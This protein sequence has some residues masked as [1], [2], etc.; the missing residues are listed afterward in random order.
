VWREDNG[1]KITSLPMHLFCFIRPKNPDTKLLDPSPSPRNFRFEGRGQKGFLFFPGLTS[2]SLFCDSECLAHRNRHFP[3]RAPRGSFSTQFLLL[4]ES[5]L[6][7]LS[8][9][10][11]R[12]L[13]SKLL[14]SPHSLF[15]QLGQPCHQ[16]HQGS[17]SKFVLDQRH[18][19]SGLS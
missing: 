16:S 17:I 5:P 9:W 10:S 18:T 6:F 8:I 13:S 1:E 7:P 14:T 4:F 15:D 11:R 19:S 12:R 2:P 3:M